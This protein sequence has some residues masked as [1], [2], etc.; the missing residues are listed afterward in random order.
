MKEAQAETAQRVSEIARLKATIG[1]LQSRPSGSSGDSPARDDEF[2]TRRRQRIERM[3]KA[4]RDR[5]RRL[6]K[7]RDVVKQQAQQVREIEDDKRTLADVRRNLEQAEQRMIRRWARSSVMTHL[8]L[9]TLTIAV[10]GAVSYFGVMTFWPTSYTARSTVDAKG[11]PGFPLTDT[12]TNLWQTVHEQMALSDSVINGVAE[13]LRQRGYTDLAEPSNLKPFLEGN[14]V[15]ASPKPGTITFELTTVGR[16]EAQRL[17]ET[18][19]IGLVSA[20][21]AER[22]RRTDGATT[23]LSVP[24]TADPLPAKDNRV[25]IAGIA[26]GSSV[27]ALL[28]L[29]LP[30]YLKL[31]RSASV[32]TDDD[33]ESPLMDTQRWSQISHGN[34]DSTEHVIS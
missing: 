28:F 12:Q 32:F 33:L 16:E 24:A 27:G 6:N 17:L 22:G 31:R 1:E 9:I 5:S 30:L 15:T 25:Q 34:T 18:Y 29:G 13:R 4:I 19:T 8:F 3:R 2:I 26:F 14:L 23:N 21:N 11:K 10:L 7:A 20:S